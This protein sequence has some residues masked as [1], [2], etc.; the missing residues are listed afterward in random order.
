ME[1]PWQQQTSM[2][3]LRS[4]SLVVF[5]TAPLVTGGCG[6]SD[7][8][9]GADPGADAG[10]GAD[11]GA[12]ADAGGGEDAGAG[13]DAGPGADT[14]PGPDTSPLVLPDGRYVIHPTSSGSTLC[15]ALEGDSF[16]DGALVQQHTCNGALAQAFDVATVSG[17]RTITNASSG[18]ALDV[19]DK[20]I[21][22]GARIQQ[23]AYAGGD[24]QRFD[25]ERQS[26]G[27]WLVRAKHDGLAFDVI[28][29]SKV[30]GAYLQQWTVVTGAVADNQRFTFEPYVPAV[31][32]P[33]TGFVHAEGIDLVD[34]SGKKVLLRGV[35]L[36]NWLVPEGYM[37]MLDGSRGDRAR[38]IEDR[39]SELIGATNAQ[40][41]FK[42]YR[43]RFI[44]E[45]DLAKIA[46]DGFDSVRVA[47]NA[48]LLMPEGGSAFDE[49]E[50]KRLT[51]L[52]TWS[53]AHGIWVIFDMHCAPGGQTG[54]NIDDSA[55]DYPELYDSAA[56]QDRLVTIWTE[57]ARRFKD[58]P[59]V[60]GY[61]LLNEPLPEADFGSLTP[62]LWP[63][64][65]K[66]GK[67]IRAVD[68]NHV[69]IVEGANWA[70]DW[71][72]LGAPFDA[73]MVYS[74]HKYWNGTDVASI[75]TYI[76][77]RKTWNRPVW[78][79]EIGE[80]DDGWYSAAFKLL[81]DNGM[82]WSFWTWKK[83]ENGNAPMSVSA[84]SGWSS[85]RDYVT[86]ASK[87]PSSAS[88][89][90]TF[91]AFLES[92]PLAKNTENRHVICAILPCK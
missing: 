59:T 32:P 46:A 83:M 80:N 41:F 53:K 40:A 65:T 50:M 45:A 67:A 7:T 52:V 68:P 38:R 27:S 71:S 23:W 39:V 25:L 17:A 89:Q 30:D 61:D 84:P 12:G 55:H 75:Q 86:D 92:I 66:V 20:S 5:L 64:L 21:A 62:K 13:G 3:H 28:D 34:G 18:K 4:L 9:A 88:A 91:D 33:K 74:F 11:T 90:A 48:R 1:R 37:W 78:V 69:L 16:A 63:V 51:D 76:D 70:N 42:G 24:N 10:V 6:S 35:A 56:N 8:G 58:E 44:T 29:K 77:H 43:D 26:D 15:L 85:F 57:I 19:K 54:K 82:G 36:G 14:G 79:G 73:N 47:M 22:P 60:L 87:K 31:V 81:E 72:T 49:T 2:A